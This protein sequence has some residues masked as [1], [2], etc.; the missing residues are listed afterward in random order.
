MILTDAL[1]VPLSQLHTKQVM[2]SLL[3]SHRIFKTDF[4]FSCAH[5]VV[6]SDKKFSLKGA[7]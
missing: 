1:I 4:S 3:R 2:T 7:F 6:K 5:F